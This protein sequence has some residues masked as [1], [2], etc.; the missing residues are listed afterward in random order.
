MNKEY[1]HAGDKP[2]KE[3]DMGEEIKLS[4]WLQ[5][6]A[7]NPAQPAEVR[8]FALGLIPQIAE[9]EKAE[10]VDRRRLRDLFDVADKLL[11]NLRTVAL[12]NPKARGHENADL[13]IVLDDAEKVVGADPADYEVAPAEPKLDPYPIMEIRQNVISLLQ[14]DA[15]NFDKYPLVEPGIFRYTVYDHLRQ[16]LVEIVDEVEAKQ[17]NP[18]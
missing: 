13:I 4:V 6:V 10:E 12:Q 18:K 1:S 3:N 2:A 5:T 14:A 16:Y 8:A 11:T 7:D 17:V 9:Q 15:D